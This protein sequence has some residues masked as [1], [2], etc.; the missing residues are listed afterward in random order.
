MRLIILAGGPASGK[1]LLTMH[2]LKGLRDKGYTLGVCKIDCIASHDKEYYRRFGV[3]VIQGLSGPI[4]PDH[5]LA[6]N[7]PALFQWGKGHDFDY[8]IIETAG[9]C[10]RCAPFTENA[11]NICVVDAMGS[12]KAP[13]KLGPILTTANC[14]VTTKSDL[15]TQ[16]ERE[17]L[18]LHVQS[19]NEQASYY[20]VN[21]LTGFG[22]RQLI[23]WIEKEARGIE[24]LEG[25]RLKYDMPS[26][27]CAY[28]VGERR[29]GTQFSQGIVYPIDLEEGN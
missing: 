1:T 20:E 14:I 22:A 8:L 3:K 26:G 28:C 4:C 6:T 24:S 9:L 25:D 23:G 5:Y 12:L 19:L 18:G 16:A 27:N 7:L 2:V 11:L 13:E 21:G 29:I 15:I 10:H 17:I